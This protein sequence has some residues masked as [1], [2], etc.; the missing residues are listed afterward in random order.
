MLNQKKIRAEAAADWAV[1]DLNIEQQG[2]VSLSFPLKAQ[3]RCTN[4][5]AHLN[6]FHELGEF[7]Y[8]A[9]LRVCMYVCVCRYLSM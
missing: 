7:V 5:F 4:P 3:S 6:A 2:I 1:A 8:Q 9:F